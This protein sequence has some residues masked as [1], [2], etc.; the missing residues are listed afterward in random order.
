MLTTDNLRVKLRLIRALGELK[1]SRAVPALKS[2]LESPESRV[3]ETVQD[4]LEKIACAAWARVDVL[5]V[6]GEIGGDRAL[7][8]AIR[9]LSD[10]NHDVRKASILLVGK[11]RDKRAIKPLLD[12]LD[13]PADELRRGA[14][15][16][17]GLIGGRSPRVAKAINNLLVADSSLEVRAEAARALGRLLHFSSISVLIEA[18]NDPYWTVREHAENALNNFAQ[19]AVKALIGALHSEHDFVRVRSARILG[20]IGGPAAVKALQAL[21]GDPKEAQEVLRIAQQ[22]LKLM[23]DMEKTKPGDLKA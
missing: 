4:G 6:L 12:V 14:V 19:R 20:N 5:T 15:R 13:S 1:D 11:L 23:Q 22:G 2:L 17:L 18:L 9:S 8:M 7:Q 10:P 21:L 3:V 16:V